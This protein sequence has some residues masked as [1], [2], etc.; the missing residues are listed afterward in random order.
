MFLFQ[1]QPTIA[2]KHTPLYRNLKKKMLITFK[3]PLATESVKTRET[4]LMLLQRE[5]DFEDPVDILYGW[6]K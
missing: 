4:K 2:A 3:V 6:R 1:G 5:V